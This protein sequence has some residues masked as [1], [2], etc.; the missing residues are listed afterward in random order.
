M[1]QGVDTRLCLPKTAW[2][3]TYTAI[4]FTP[5][6]SVTRCTHNQITSFK[7]AASS[8]TSSYTVVTIEYAELHHTHII[9]TVTHRTFNQTHCTPSHTQHDRRRTLDLQLNTSPYIKVSSSTSPD[10]AIALNTSYTSRTKK[11]L[12]AHRSLMVHHR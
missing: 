5:F 9:H 12:V 6:S 11:Q 7:I 4:A 2:P 8:G 1:S 3:P 10:I